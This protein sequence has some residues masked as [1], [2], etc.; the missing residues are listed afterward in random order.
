MTIK[1]LKYFVASWFAGKEDAPKEARK[2]EEHTFIETIVS[3]KIIARYFEHN[4]QGYNVFG[5]PELHVTDENTQQSWIEEA[6]I[7][8]I[9]KGSK[10]VTG[11]CPIHIEKIAL[12]KIKEWK[13]T[14][15]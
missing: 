14:E 4:G 13:K 2:K 5:K 6:Q 3:S 15:C 7:L 8:K 11:T 1:E 10:D 9:M 12:N